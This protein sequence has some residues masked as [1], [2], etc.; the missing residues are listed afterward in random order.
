M[1]QKLKKNDNS[2]DDEV[3][4]YESE[5]KGVFVIQDE[6]EIPLEK[7]TKQQQSIILEETPFPEGLKFVIGDSEDK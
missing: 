6:E 4:A 1:V 3:V 2:K 5:T 7:N